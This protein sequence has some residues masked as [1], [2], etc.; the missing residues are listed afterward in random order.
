[1]MSSV[2]YGEDFA[3]QVQPLAYG[4]VVDR[5]GVE[6]SLSPARRGRPRRGPPPQP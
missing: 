5:D 4:E 3:G 6:V 2:G 1:M